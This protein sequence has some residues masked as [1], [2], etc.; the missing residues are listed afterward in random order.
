MANFNTH[1]LVATGVSGTLALGLFFTG[2]ASAKAVFF[3]WLLGT[4]GGI[5]PDIDAPRSIPVRLLF[6]G[7]GILFA[8]FIVVSQS[9][10]LA[11]LELILLWIII[12]IVVRY[13][14]LKLF[15]Q[16]TVHRGHFHSILAALLFGLIVTV[17]SYHVLEIRAVVAWF[18]GFFVIVGYLVHLLLD[19]L[20]SVDIMN[21]RFK[22]SFGSAFKLANTRH[23]FSTL[24]LI[25]LT[26]WIL[27]WTPGMDKFINS[28]NL[29]QFLNHLLEN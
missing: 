17:V 4:I 16:L 12:F 8:S 5:L 22:K 10:H 23:K 19:E 27:Q 6:I 7:I 20:Y 15:T 3:Y 2:W 1:L 24:V 26:I 28:I 14:L 21:Q 9:Q 29:T 25:L 11:W 18:A 13:G